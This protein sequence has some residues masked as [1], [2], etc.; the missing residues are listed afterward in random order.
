MVIEQVNNRSKILNASANY[1]IITKSKP[2][3]DLWLPKTYCE[4]LLLLPLHH[5]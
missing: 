1:N 4:Q 2:L 5:L 3:C